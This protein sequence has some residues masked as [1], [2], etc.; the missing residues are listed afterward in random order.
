MRWLRT[1]GMGKDGHENS[2]RQE[3]E[4]SSIIL[5]FLPSVTDTWKGDSSVIS[6]FLF[7]SS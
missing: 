4:D 2:D 5:L 7:V 1:V 3:K 6:Y